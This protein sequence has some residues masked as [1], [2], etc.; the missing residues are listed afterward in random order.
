MII[1]SEANEQA[2]HFIDIIYWPLL[3]GKINEELFLKAIIFK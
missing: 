2:L 3:R 1:V